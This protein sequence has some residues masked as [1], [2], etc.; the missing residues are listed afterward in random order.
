MFLAPFKAIRPQPQKINRIHKNVIYED[1][2]KPL[3]GI[4]NLQKDKRIAYHHYENPSYK[5]KEDVYK[6]EYVLGF[7]IIQFLSYMSSLQL[8]IL[9][10]FPRRA[11]FSNPNLYLGCLSLI[12]Y[13][14]D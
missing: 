8:K 4:Q 1:I 14:Y 7:N 9:I 2:A 11:H 3:L 12:F 13:H 10:Y 6:C 5:I